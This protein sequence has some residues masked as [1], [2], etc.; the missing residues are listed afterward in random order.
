MNDGEQ[1]QV[2]EDAQGNQFICCSDEVLIVA[3]N[4]KGEVLFNIEPSPAFNG[5]KVLVLPGGSTE[6]GEPHD[7]TANRELQE[8]AGYKAKRLA[9]L[10]ELRPWTKYLT[11]RSHAYL[12]QDLARSEREGDEGFE[13]E[14]EQHPLNN[15]ESLIETGRLRD[16]RVIAALYMARNFLNTYTHPNQQ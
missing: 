15:F 11:V 3:L 9:Y 13:V 7:K 4:D 12:A 5:E 2:Q 14:I 1:F 6:P 8:E 16:A 10:G